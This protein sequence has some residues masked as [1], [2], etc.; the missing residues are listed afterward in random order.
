M[1]FTWIT[2]GGF[3]FESASFR[4]AIDPYLSDFVEKKSNVTRMVEPVFSVT[5][6]KPDAVFCTHDHIDHF[7]PI[8]VPQIAKAFPSCIFAGPVSVAKKAI[9]AKINGSKILKVERGIPINLGPFE[10]IPVVAI[11]SDKDAVG[12]ILKC[13][14]KTLYISGDSE[15]SESIADEVLKYAGGKIDMIFICI[16]GRLGNMNLGDALKVVK[17][18]RPET[19]L[20]M[21]Y[22]LFAENSAAPEPFIAECLSEN[23]KSFEMKQGKECII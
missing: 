3:L 17:A 2:Q 12:I 16:N 9:E 22:D 8:T 11:H 19:A 13:E 5:T 10:I 21:H 14:G 6:L 20:P 7:D 18:I 23:I 1:K 15:Y 4:L